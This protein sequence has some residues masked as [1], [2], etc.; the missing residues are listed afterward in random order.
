MLKRWIIAAFIT[1]LAL[2]LIDRASLPFAPCSERNSGQN[3][4]KSADDDNC[5][6]RE[7]L[8]VAGMERLSE[9][10]P[11]VWT[12]L[13]TVAIA[14]FTLTLWLS[15]EKMWKITKIS[16]D[17]AEMSAKAAI[18]LELPIIRA[19]AQKLGYGSSQNGTEQRHCISIDELLLSNLGR[20]KAFPIEIQI[21]CTIGNRLPKTPVYCFSKPFPVNTLWEPGHRERVTLREFDFDATPDI[22]ERL[23]TRRIHLWFYCNLVYLDFMQ[24]RHE[25]SFCWKRNE[26]IGTGTFVEDASP[27][28]NRKT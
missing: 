26:S 18:A 19:H 5:P 21:G 28:Y 6:V 27:A 14:A 12:A 25:L 7:G 11:D 1:A 16:A 9:I 15:S 8:I 24:T 4:Q 17:A 13:A 23:R 22:Y 20:T 2:I 10:P 3:N